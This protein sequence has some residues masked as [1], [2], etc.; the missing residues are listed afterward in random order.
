[1]ALADVT[2]TPEADGAALKTAINSGEGVAKVD[3]RSIPNVR[4][5]A[6]NIIKETLDFVL[7]SI[8]HTR[9]NMT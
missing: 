8:E 3:L 4:A 2:A 6:L 7:Q 1:M 5:I 9:A